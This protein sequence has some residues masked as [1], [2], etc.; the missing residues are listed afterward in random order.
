MIKKKIIIFSTTRADYGILEN[1]ISE[2]LIKNKTN[3]YLCLTG[4]LFSKKY[5]YTINLIKTKIPNKNIYNIKGLYFNK[6]DSP[7]LIKNITSISL[8]LSKILKKNKFDSAVLLGD[9]YELLGITVPLFFYNVPIIHLHGGETTKGSYDDKIRNI[10]SIL[11]SLNFTSNIK[12]QKNLERLLN[13]KSNIYNF[14]SLAVEHIENIK[15]FCSKKDLEN[16]LKIKFSKKNLMVLIH[17]ETN[18]VKDFNDK[19]NK[20]FNF[21]ENKSDYNIFF[22]SPGHDIGGNY[23][24][25]KINKITKKKNCYFLNTVGKKYFYS[26]AKNCDL[27]ISNS[28]SGIIEMPSL[29]VPVINLGSRQLGRIQSKN[30]I[31]ST[32]DAKDLEN[33]F[34][35]VFSKKFQKKIIKVKNAYY[36]KNTKKNIVE[37]ILKF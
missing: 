23:I 13:K 11:S 32:F 16:K 17:A 6:D 35:V 9:R 25:K 3:I 30:I 8:K 4:S 37:M 19:I 14:G 12:Y 24:F 5:G 1:L 21:L 18:D 7:T 2:L 10:V 36:V 28:S 15:K 31:N 27:I 22:T 26:L 29:K 33:K 20:L 34:K